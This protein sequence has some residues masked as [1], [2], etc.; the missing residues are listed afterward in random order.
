MPRESSLSSNDSE[1]PSFKPSQLGTVSRQLAAKPQNLHRAD[2]TAQERSDQVAKW[3][4]LVEAK[5]ARDRQLRQVGAAALSDGR[6][7]GP[8]HEEGGTRADSHRGGKA[9]AGESAASCRSFRSGRK[10]QRRRHPRRCPR[11]WH[12]RTPS[13]PRQANLQHIRRCQEGSRIQVYPITQST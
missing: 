8:Q 7:A 5:R 11:A 2:L 1:P 4:E 6:K 9:G 13:P 3:I 10:G 12:Q